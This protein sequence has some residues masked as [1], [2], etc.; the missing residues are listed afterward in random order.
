[1]LAFC[2]RSKTHR[3]ACFLRRILRRSLAFL[4]RFLSAKT[5]RLYKFAILRSQTSPVVGVRVFVALR[6]STVPRRLRSD[7]DP[8][9]LGGCFDAPPLGVRRAGATVTA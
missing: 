2:S 3:A 7:G 6:A 4:F 8:A 1:V 9:R 5:E